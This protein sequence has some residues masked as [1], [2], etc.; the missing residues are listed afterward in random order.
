M[1][2]FLIYLIIVIVVFGAIVY[3][4]RV[5]PIQEPFKSA[6]YILILLVFVLILLS[7]L[8]VIPGGPWPRPIP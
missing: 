1:I 5:L 3:A 6:A 4:I 8:G 2:S 7:M